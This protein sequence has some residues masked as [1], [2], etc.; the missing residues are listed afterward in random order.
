MSVSDRRLFIELLEYGSSRLLMDLLES[1]DYS[2]HRATE[3]GIIRLLLIDLQ[4]SI[5]YP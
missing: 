5:D 4:G 3:F 1:L 2:S